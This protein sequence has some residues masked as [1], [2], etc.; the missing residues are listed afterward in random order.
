M[1]RKEAALCQLWVGC[2]RSP[3]A[4][5]NHTSD[6]QNPK[7]RIAA[8]QIPSQ[9]PGMS[10]QYRKFSCLCEVVRSPFS[11]WV[12]FAANGARREAD[13]ERRTVRGHLLSPPLAEQ[14]RA[15]PGNSGQKL[16]R[17]ALTGRPVCPVCPTGRRLRRSGPA[18]FGC[19]TL[20]HPR[21]T[22]R[23]FRHLICDQDAPSMRLGRSSSARSTRVSW[24]TL[25]DIS[26]PSIF[27]PLFS[28]LFSSQGKDAMRARIFPSYALPGATASQSP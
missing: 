28:L 10:T 12:H 16:S 8:S 20:A 6:L 18:V 21:R 22:E 26:P 4:L 19:A 15:I 25:F 11:A 5:E 7:M 13:R 3:T 2:I 17:E 24:A 9:I 27:S 23:P 1:F 14:F